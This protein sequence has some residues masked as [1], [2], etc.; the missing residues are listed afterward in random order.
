MSFRPKERVVAA[1]RKF[2]KHSNRRTENDGEKSENVQ[3]QNQPP[4]SPARK[5]RR[6]V[7]NLFANIYQCTEKPKK[8]VNFLH[9]IFICRGIS[10]STNNKSTSKKAKDITI[11]TKR[12]MKEFKEIQK[13]QHMQDNP[14]F[15]VGNLFNYNL[16][17]I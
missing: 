17:S 7:M 11:R 14:A 13:S 4:K 9:L 16:Q 15:T 10:P 5:S 12:L 6:F 3:I 8:H 1:I 2:F